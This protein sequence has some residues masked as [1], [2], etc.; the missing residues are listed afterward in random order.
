MPPLPVI[1]WEGLAHGTIGKL[2]QFCFAARHIKRQQTAFL[3]DLAHM[4]MIDH[5]HIEI[6]GQFLD[7]KG[8][9]IL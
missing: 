1:A 4:R 6:A 3:G 2:F 5:D 8:L 9:E 7:R